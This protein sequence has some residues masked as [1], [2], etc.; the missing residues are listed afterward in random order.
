MSEGW[1]IQELH[2][3]EEHFGNLVIDSIKANSFKKRLLRDRC[4]VWSK[5]VG[6]FGWMQLEDVLNVIGARF[7]YD[8]NDDYC[9]V[10][11]LISHTIQDW[12]AL[13]DKALIKQIVNSLPGRREV[14]CVIAPGRGL[15][16]QAYIIGMFLNLRCFLK[17]Q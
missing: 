8:Q 17:N 15:W 12:F 7:E 2:Y 9:R 3:S 4:Q 13:L 11:K 5:L 1:E 16:F 10:I 14:K 6:N